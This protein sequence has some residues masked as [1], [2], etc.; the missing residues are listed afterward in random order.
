[1]T[2]QSVISWS[3]RDYCQAPGHT[4]Q[5]LHTVTKPKSVTD[6]LTVTQRNKDFVVYMLLIHDTCRL[7]NQFTC[8]CKLRRNVLTFS[9]VDEV[10]VCSTVFCIDNLLS[11]GSMLF[12]ETWVNASRG[13]VICTN[14]DPCSM[15]FLYVVITLVNIVVSNFRVSIEPCRFDPLSLLPPGISIPS[16]RRWHSSYELF[17]LPVKSKDCWCPLVILS[18]TECQPGLF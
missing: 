7:R 9:F 10:S 2:G 6:G 18:S 3:H 4:G 5:E 12:L 15:Q 1:M 11:A 8:V 14:P 17:C 16:A 13:V